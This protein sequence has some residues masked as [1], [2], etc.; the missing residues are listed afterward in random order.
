[1]PHIASVGQGVAEGF[2]I[3]F[4]SPEIPRI[5]PSWSTCWGT[6]FYLFFLSSIENHS[7]HFAFLSSRSYK[8]NFKAFQYTL[9][10]L[11]FSVHTLHTLAS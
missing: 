5:R 1:M 8:K 9:S 10:E 2:L 7:A 4:F 11:D 3:E 6:F